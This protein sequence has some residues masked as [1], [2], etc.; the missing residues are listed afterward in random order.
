PG[1]DTASRPDR[2]AGGRTGPGP[3][4]PHAHVLVAR[5]R[6]GD[7]RRDRGRGRPPAL[8]GGA[9]GR[10]PDP[11]L[12]LAPS[13]GSGGVTRPDRLASGRIS[14][15]LLGSPRTAASAAGPEGQAR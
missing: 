7:G 4:R 3:R 12:R 6:G 2:P 11:W 5:S 10:V 15:R 14:A 1:A 9:Q 8:G 13:S